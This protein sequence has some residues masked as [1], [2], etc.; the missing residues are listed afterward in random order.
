[1]LDY[2]TRK[3]TFLILS[4]GHRL[5]QFMFQ[6]GDEFDKGE[7]Y[8]M[9]IPGFDGHHKVFRTVCERLKMPAIAIQP[10]LDHIEESIPEM[11][12]RLAQVC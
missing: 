6:R 12:S 2:N 4:N 5:K 11:G 9:M 3:T 1:M 10:G 7:N 8:M